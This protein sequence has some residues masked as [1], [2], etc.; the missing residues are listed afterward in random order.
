[1][2][3]PPF[4]KVSFKAGKDWKTPIPSPLEK[5]QPDMA[6]NGQLEM[7]ISREVVNR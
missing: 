3:L 1:M 7:F 5:G 6:E 2:Y 4:K